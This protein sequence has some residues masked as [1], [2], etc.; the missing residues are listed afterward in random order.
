LSETLLTSWAKR[1]ALYIRAERNA[2]PHTLRA[3]E[4]EIRQYITFVHAHY[5]SLSLTRTHRVVIREYLAY[6]HDGDLKRVSVLR[7]IAVLRAFY[8]FLMREEAVSQ[9]PFV[10]IPMPK[11]EKRLPYFLSEAEMN[12]L[13]DFPGTTRQKHAVRDAALMELLYSSGVRIQELCQLNVSDVDMWSGLVR[14]MGKGSRERLVPVGKTALA[15]IRTYLDARPAAQQRSGPLFLSPKGARMTDR[16][17]RLAVANWVQQ[18]ALHKRVTPHAFRHSFAT[19]LLNHGCDLRTV[20]E[21]LG[22]KSLT[23]TQTYTHVSQE[24]LQN[25]YRKAHPRA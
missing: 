13:L 18:A 1:F 10:G 25:V 3:Y 4:R 17:A 15:R 24:H 7:A 11:R 9:S 16:T 8:K 21:L 19:H 20:Q 12:T 2:S 5:P 6:L 23:T 22:H 14:V